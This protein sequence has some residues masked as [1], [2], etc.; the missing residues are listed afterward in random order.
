M[1]LQ[2]LFMICIILYLNKIYHCFIR[3]FPPNA[4]GQAIRS[5]FCFVPPQK[6]ATPI[7]NANRLSAILRDIEY[8]NTKLFSKFLYLCRIFKKYNYWKLV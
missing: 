4:H 8:Q 5:I 6:D 7:L 2:N 1:A 3:A